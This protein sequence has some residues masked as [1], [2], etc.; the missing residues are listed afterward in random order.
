[1]DQAGFPGMHSHTGLA[2]HSILSSNLILLKDEKVHPW[3]SSTAS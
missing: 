1:M 2:I 3:N